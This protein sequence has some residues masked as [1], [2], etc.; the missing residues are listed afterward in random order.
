MLHCL[1]NSSAWN[2][3]PVIYI[4]WAILWENCAFA[5]VCML[6]NSNQT[7]DMIWSMALLFI[8]GGMRAVFARI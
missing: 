4:S 8:I 3:V 2:V 5:A 7:V 1:N 6:I